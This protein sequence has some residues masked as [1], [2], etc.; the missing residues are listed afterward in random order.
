MLWRN[1]IHLTACSVKWLIGCSK[2]NFKLKNK[3]KNNADTMKNIHAKRNNELLSYD[4]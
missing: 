2:K 4:K 1:F 3:L